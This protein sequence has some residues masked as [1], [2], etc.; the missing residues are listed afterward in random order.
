MHDQGWFH[1]DE[2]R[3]GSPVCL[4][5][6]KVSEEKV[7]QEK[8]CAKREKHSSA[9]KAASRQPREIADK[10]GGDG[11][12]AGFLAENVKR[13]DGGI[14]RETAAQNGNL[15][16]EPNGKIIAITPDKERTGRQKEVPKKS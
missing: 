1:W 10:R 13:A 8:K 2:N 3:K 11:F 9:I 12:E 15:I 4:G 7:Q 5:K 6:R 14:T 16:L